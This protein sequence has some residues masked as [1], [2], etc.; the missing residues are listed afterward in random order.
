MTEQVVGVG[1]E[2]T[3][4]QS[5]V[6]QLPAGL[7]GQIWSSNLPHP[8]AG[9]VVGGVTVATAV[10]VVVWALST[11]IEG[12]LQGAVGGAAQRGSGHRLCSGHAFGSLGRGPSRQLCGRP[13]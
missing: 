1:G 12:A 3:G 11:S 13:Q 6:K 4:M 2:F 9:A 8:P 10:V 7:V 5:W